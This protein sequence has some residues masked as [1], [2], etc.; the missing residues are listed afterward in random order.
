M[1]DVKVQQLIKQLRTRFKTP[2][3]KQEVRTSASYWCLFGLFTLLCLTSLWG[4][5]VVILAFLAIAALVN[6]PLVFLF[7]LIYTALFSLFPPLAFLFS[8]ILLIR[9]CF[10]FV[11][12]WRFGVFATYFYVMPFL[13]TW[14]LHQSTYPA[15]VTKWSLLLISL[16]LFYGLSE[17]V[18]TRSKNSLGLLWSVISLPYDTVLFVIPKRFSTR[19]SRQKHLSPVRKHFK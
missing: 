12:N 8:L 13:F 14:L 1:G 11:R 16:G 19:F 6:G 2:Q 4:K 9:E 5:L 15:S 10:F 7:G 3:T 17:L 18:Y